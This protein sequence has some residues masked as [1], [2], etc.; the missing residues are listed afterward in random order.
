[1]VK[2]HQRVKRPSVMAMPYARMAWRGASP[3]TKAASAS[4]PASTSRKHSCPKPLKTGTRQFTIC[5][6]FVW[7]E[8]SGFAGQKTQQVQVL[9]MT[10]LPEL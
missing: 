3:L 5:G 4:I 10:T 7:L 8:V 9:P 6:R 1:M 2:S